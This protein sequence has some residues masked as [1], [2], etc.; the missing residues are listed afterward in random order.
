MKYRA[1]VNLVCCD[2]KCKIDVGEPDYPIAA[3]S[4]GKQ[5]LL[6]YYIYRYISALT[7]VLV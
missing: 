2:D 6:C 1:D 7:T 4:R 5:V 3:V